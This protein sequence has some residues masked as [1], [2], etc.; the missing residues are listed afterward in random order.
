M[1]DYPR[2]AKRQGIQGQVVVRIVVDKDGNPQACAVHSAAPEG[3][4]EEVALQ[5]ARQMRFIP[6]KVKGA[7]VNT[8]V[9]VPF[10][11]RLQ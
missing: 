2:S 11:F 1:P 7:P 9:S 6:G 3:Y 10:V 4:F 8:L 5:A